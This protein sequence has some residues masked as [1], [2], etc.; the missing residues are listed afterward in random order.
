VQLTT[1][2]RSMVP[3]VA[4]VSVPASTRCT[5]SLPEYRRVE[6]RDEVLGTARDYG[7]EVGDRR[8]RASHPPNRHAAIP[9][10]ANSMMS[11]PVKGN[12]EAPVEGPFVA[13][14]WGVTTELC[15]EGPLTPCT[16]EFTTGG[17]QPT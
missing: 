14:D 5:G 8:R 9:I 2:T 12:D 13:A 1:W 17:V 4:D 3:E 6:R 16:D 15:T 7:D 11:L 10:V